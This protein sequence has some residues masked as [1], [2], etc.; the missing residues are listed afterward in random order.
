METASPRAPHKEAIMNFDTSLDV[1]CLVCGAGTNE[2]CKTPDGSARVAEHPRRVQV[3]RL[4]RRLDRISPVDEATATEAV[5]ADGYR[6][7]CKLT[8]RFK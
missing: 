5:D 1:P 2:R 7:P 4:V 3:L 6:I 8:V